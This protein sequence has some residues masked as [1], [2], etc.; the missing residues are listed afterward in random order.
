[1]KTNNPSRQKEQLGSEE[2]LT[3]ETPAII[4]E[5]SISTRAG[6]PFG[7]PGDDSGVDPADLFGK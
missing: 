3:Y 1:M 2:K 6:T 7:S 5:S 4:H